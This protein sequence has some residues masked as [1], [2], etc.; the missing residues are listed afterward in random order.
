MEIE[1]CLYIVPTPIG[2]LSDITLRAIEVL[3]GVDIIAC[4]DTRRSG[5]L[6]KSLNIP[7]RSRLRSYFD[8]NEERRSLELIDEIRSGKSVALIS[9]AGTPC[10]S[11]PGF[12]L[13]RLAR[14]S[15]IKIIS[16][17]GAV[18]FVPSLVA[19]GFPIHS[20]TF[21]GFPPQ[22]KGRQ[23]FLKNA[24]SNPHTLVFYESSHRILRFLKEISSIDSSRQ[25]FVSREISKIYE[26]HLC[27]SAMDFLCGNVQITDKGEFVVVVSSL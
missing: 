12:R 25:I 9:D 5:L 10:I 11:D 1:I 19:S 21:F 22:K 17:P 14:N 8:F 4:E 7:N 26:E 24:F 13:V 6:L 2:N 15:G 3:S 16:L 27:F 23:L 18:A 20:F